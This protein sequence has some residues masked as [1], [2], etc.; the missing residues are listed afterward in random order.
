MRYKITG[1][2][3]EFKQGGAVRSPLT[4]FKESLHG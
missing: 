1:K 2:K 3:P 4:H